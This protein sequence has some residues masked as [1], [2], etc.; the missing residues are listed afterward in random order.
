[1]NSERTAS[2]IYICPN[3]EVGGGGGGY[4]RRQRVGERDRERTERAGGTAFRE[5]SCGWRV[6]PLRLKLTT[7]AVDC[8]WGR[9][10][11]REHN[12]TN[13]TDSPLRK[14]VFAGTRHRPWSKG[15]N[16]VCFVQLNVLFWSKSSGE[17]KRGAPCSS[18]PRLNW[19]T[20]V[21]CWEMWPCNG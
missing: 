6:A 11:N 10:A 18:T 17:A 15:S 9:V 20:A 1:M 7:T 2:N 8:R 14:S 13:T 3:P 16:V 12:G 21:L 4:G 19:R 5:C